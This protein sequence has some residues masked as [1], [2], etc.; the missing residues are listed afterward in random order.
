MARTKINLENT[1]TLTEINQAASTGSVWANAA[2][3]LIALVQAK[4]LAYHEYVLIGTFKAAT[5]AASA[6]RGLRKKI[7]AG[8]VRLEEPVDFRPIKVNDPKDPDEQTSELWACVC[9]EEIEP[10]DVDDED[11]DEWETGNDD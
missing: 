3:D 9:D 2:N 5:G 10:A 8:K 11:E 4:E 7:E 1:K 6:F